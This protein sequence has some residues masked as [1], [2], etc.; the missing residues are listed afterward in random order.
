MIS[1]YSLTQQQQQ[2][3]SSS[4]ASS[5]SSQPPPVQNRSRFNLHLTPLPPVRQILDRWR[6]SLH[7]P[8][9]LEEW[10]E[11]DSDPEDEDEQVESNDNNSQQQQ[12]PYQNQTIQQYRQ[13]K[14]DS[15]RHRRRRVLVERWQIS[16]IPTSSSSSSST[17][18]PISRPLPPPPLPTQ[19]I[20]ILQ[21]LRL[22]CKKIIIL[23][24]TIH[25]Y[26]NMS[27]GYVVHRAIHERRSPNSSLE[28]SQQSSGSG[29]SSGSGERVLHGTNNLKIEHPLTRLI[30]GSEKLRAGSLTFTFR[31]SNVPASSPSSS[32]GNNNNN[33]DRPPE[34]MD[35]MDNHSW[36]LED[37]ASNTSGQTYP[38]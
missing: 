27:S 16:Y 1:N 14:I 13:L 19:P 25:C 6:G 29:G 15:N 30:R 33:D 12:D 34:N 38:S 22:V 23:L 2:Q 31:K 21:S 9:F 20:D 7:I 36:F 37:P 8:V 26:S 3:N 32:G 17:S 28:G 11:Y 18:D 4:S 35:P 5:S 24:R 10:L